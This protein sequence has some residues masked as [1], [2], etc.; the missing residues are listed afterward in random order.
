MHADQS[1]GQGCSTHLLHEIAQLSVW[2]QAPTHYLTCLSYGLRSHAENG[3]V[4]E[5][6]CLYCSSIQPAYLP[7]FC[8]LLKACATNTKFSIFCRRDS[9]LQTQWYHLIKG[10][11][12]DR[13]NAAKLRPSC[14]QV[15]IIYPASLS[16]EQTQPSPI[17]A[18][19]QPAQRERRRYRPSRASHGPCRTMGSGRL[20]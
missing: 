17:A 14:R 12:D 3:A 5:K 13:I 9:L 11:Q 4:A 20:G 1:G 19:R 2:G 7:V 8:F 18:F 6:P 15:L 16:K 10:I